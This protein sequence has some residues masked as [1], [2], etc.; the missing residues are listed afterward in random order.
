M[1][2]PRISAKR[3]TFNNCATCKRLISRISNSKTDAHN[4]GVHHRNMQKQTAPF[5]DNEVVPPLAK[6]RWTPR[7]C[8][9]R[10]RGDAIACQLVR[11]SSSIHLVVCRLSFLVLGVAW[12][13]TAIAATK[14]SA[15]RCDRRSPRPETFS[16]APRSNVLLT[17][18]SGELGMPIWGTP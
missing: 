4:Q 6:P 11:S 14:P 5:V 8:H 3:A 9:T 18:A 10:A 2:K 17:F 16:L 1:A 7:R 15:R 13:R 12:S